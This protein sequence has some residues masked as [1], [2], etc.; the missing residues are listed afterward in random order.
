M[1][2]YSSAYLRCAWKRDGEIV[3]RA[4]ILEEYEAR[5]RKIEL[6]KQVEFKKRMGNEL[7]P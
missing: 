4:D 5:K 6:Q 3:D 7:L 2:V 1:M